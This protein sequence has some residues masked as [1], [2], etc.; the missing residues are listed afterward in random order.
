[1]YQRQLWQWA[2][3]RKQYLAVVFAMLFSLFALSGCDQSENP[4][5]NKI[6]ASLSQNSNSQDAKAKSE[7]STDKVT[8]SKVVEPKDM[9]SIVGTRTLAQRYAG[10]DVTIL[11]ASELQLD[12]A[13]A[14]V[15]TFSVPLEPNTTAVFV[16]L[17]RKYARRTA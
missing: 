16:F 9:K 2:I 15:V 14:M 6:H 1:M 10:K 8:E 7:A 11:D 5:K 3:R 12:G 13:S 17:N 4:E